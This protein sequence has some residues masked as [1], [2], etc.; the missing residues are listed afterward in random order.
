MPPSLSDRHPGWLQANSSRILS[1]RRIFGSVSLDSLRSGS[2]YPGQGAAVASARA[3]LAA[4]V[5]PQRR[6]WLRK[7]APAE[8]RPGIYFD[9]GFGVGKTHLLASVWHLAETPKAYGT[10]VEYTHLVGA[11][12]FNRNC[13]G[14]VGPDTGVH[15]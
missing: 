13:R 3:F 5:A 11:L 1:R 15:R 10:F 6:R 12:G 14:P 8:F 2:N 7:A 4:G 9:G